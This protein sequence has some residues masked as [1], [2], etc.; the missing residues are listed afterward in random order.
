M[1]FSDLP[2]FLTVPYNP[3]SVTRELREFHDPRLSNKQP[4]V[5]PSEYVSVLS[6]Q[7]SLGKSDVRRLL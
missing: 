7:V 2:D 6:H 5:Q 4:T 3:I 1:Y